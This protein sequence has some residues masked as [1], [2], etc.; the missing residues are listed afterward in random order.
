MRLWCSK[1]DISQVNLYCS[2]L[3]ILL[4]KLVQCGETITIIMGGGL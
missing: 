1:G 3:S 2:S 4:G